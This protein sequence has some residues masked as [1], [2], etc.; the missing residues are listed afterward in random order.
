MLFRMKLGYYRSILLAVYPQQMMIKVFFYTRDVKRE[1]RTLGFCLWS[2]RD[3]LEFLS[4]VSNYYLLM[5]LKT[6]TLFYVF[7]CV[8]AYVHVQHMQ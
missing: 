5:L 8:P 6:L 4:R 2:E 7:L 3:K 1:N